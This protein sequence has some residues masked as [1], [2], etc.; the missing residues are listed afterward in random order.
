MSL[1]K[2]ILIEF[3][4]IFKVIVILNK[5]EIWVLLNYYYYF[6]F[7]HSFPSFFLEFIY[8]SINKKGIFNL[9]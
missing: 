2:T 9:F 1:L 6:F 7:S 5:F 8:Y 4:K 3:M